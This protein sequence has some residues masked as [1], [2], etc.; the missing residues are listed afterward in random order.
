V[1]LSSKNMTVFVGN[2]KRYTWSV[3]IGPG[4]STR[5]GEFRVQSLSVDHHSSIYNNE[6]M[7]HSIFYD[8]NRA[9]HGTSKNIERHETHGCIAL[10]RENAEALFKLVSRNRTDTRINVQR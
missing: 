3:A 10:P 4:K 1:D 6:P 7:P 9:I 8:G 2:Q 5:P